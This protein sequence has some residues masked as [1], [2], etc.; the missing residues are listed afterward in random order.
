M[1][2]RLVFYLSILTGLLIGLTSCDEDNLIEPSSPTAYTTLRG[3]VLDV[4]TQQVVPSALVTLSPSGRVASANAAGEFRF[5]SVTAGSYTLQAI[6]TGFVSQTASVSVTAAPTPSITLLLTQVT[7]VKPANQ[8]PTAPALVSP[9]L[10]STAT[11][12]SVT[13]KWKATDPDRDTLTYDVLFYK[14][15][16]STPV[17]SYTGLRT[18]SLVVSN[19]EYGTT[20]LWQVIV[21][22]G[23]STVNG[24]IWTFTTG[25]FPNFSYVFARLV[26]GQYQLFASNGSG[27]A[28]QLTRN[29]SNWRPI[30][31]P[32]RQQIAYISTATNDLQLFVMNTDGSNQR[33]VTTVPVNGLY[34]T[35]ISFCWSPDGSQLLY[36]SNNRLYAIRTDG[37]GLR[38]VT[39]ASTG[40]VFAG[41]DWTAQGNEIVA[42]TTGTSVYDNEISI[43]RTD[44]SEV[45][46]VF[47]Q[48][49]RRVGNPVYSVDGRQLV[50]SVDSS[51][52][53]NE[54]GR[55][56][57]ARLLL[58][59]LNT[60]GIID[61]SVPRSLSQTSSTNTAAKAAGTNDLDPQFSPSG[62][63]IIFT[64]SV[65]TV[66]GERSVY[67]IDLSG[68]GAS[69][70][71][72]LI[73]SADMPYWRRQ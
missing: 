67:A 66:T 8:P 72:L 39:Q 30:A 32:N 61:L 2:V 70:R 49:N 48:R 7:V 36:P 18:D 51:G 37:S 40:R 38:L 28:V 68:S 56:L 1:P 59:N 44:G 63:Q 54:Q 4:T 11:A 55:Q 17:S 41:C 50:F 19:L 33:Q 15:G 10:N 13:V 69:N 57:D 27:S 58:L 73:S 65:S 62:S 21:R 3:R 26:N 47:T 46:S 34:A 23:A 42:R 53:M 52:F 16:T 5:D 64:N 9:A 29:G 12:T 25:S 24:P 31:S 71:R 43:F 20:Y 45:R 60:N 22:D 14:A 35:D 6:K